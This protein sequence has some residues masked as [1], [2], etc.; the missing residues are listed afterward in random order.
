MKPESVEF[1]GKYAVPN[2]PL[3]RIPEN[4]VT[5]IGRHSERRFSVLYPNGET[6]TVDASD[7]REMVRS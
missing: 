1:G 3:L 6:L 7:L 4:V 2:F 5:V